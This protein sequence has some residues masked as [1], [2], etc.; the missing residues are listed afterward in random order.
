MDRIRILWLVLP[1]IAAV[2]VL[3]V[4]LDGLLR[5]DARVLPSV[6][7]GKPAPEFEL[8]GLGERPGLATANLHEPGVKLVNVWASWCVPCRAEHPQIVKLVSEGV[9]I[10]GLNYKDEPENAEAFLAKLGDPFTRIGIDANGRTGIDFG[11]YGVPETF[12]INAWGLIT[13][14]HIGPI[15]ER[16]IDKLRAAIE[17]AGAAE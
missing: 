6:L 17:A 2:A 8:P 9:T 12:V 4:F 16:N 1:L 7:I 3:G 14:K 15:L 13:Y 5:D 10:H 11:V